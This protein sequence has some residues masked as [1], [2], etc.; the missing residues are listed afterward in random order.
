MGEGARGGW[1]SAGYLLGQTSSEERMGGW[2]GR[3]ERQPGLAALQRL[4]K[5]LRE[6]ER[7]R[8]HDISVAHQRT[9]PASGRLR[10]KSSNA[11]TQPTIICVL[12]NVN[13][14]AHPHAQQ[15]T[16]EGL[17]EAALQHTLHPHSTRLNAFLSAS[18]RTTDCHVAAGPTAGFP[19]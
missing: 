10:E 4:G 6:R 3:A 13:P 11:L 8:W 15:R 17:P 19:L 14:P 9:A 16:I 18:G 2:H 12:L 7:Y 5:L 1:L